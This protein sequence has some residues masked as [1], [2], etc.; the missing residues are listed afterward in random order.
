MDSCIGILL[1]S[2]YIRLT[3]L[4]FT[5]AAIQKHPGVGNVEL[6]MCSHGWKDGFLAHK[7]HT[8]RRDVFHL[9]AIV[10]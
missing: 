7:D 5:V 3:N 6:V 4:Q 2:C 1:L 10:S 8:N 9:Y